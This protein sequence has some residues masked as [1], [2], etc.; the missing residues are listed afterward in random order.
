VKKSL[1]AQPFRAAR[2]PWC[3]P[4]GMRYERPPADFFKGP[5][6]LRYVILVRA[7]N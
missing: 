1:V 5:E 7:L 3:R 4:E 6:G 2:R